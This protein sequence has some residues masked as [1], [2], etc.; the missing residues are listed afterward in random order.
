MPVE[1]EYARSLGLTPEATI[2]RFAERLADYGAD[3]RR[4]AAGSEARVVAEALAANGARRVGIPT[5]L[6]AALRPA[7]RRADRGLGAA[8]ARRRRP[9]GARRGRDHVLARDRGDRNDL[10]HRSRRRRATG[11]DAR[12]RPARVRGA[13]R[14]RRRER[15]GGDRRVGRGRPR[16]PADHVGVRAVRDERHRDEPRRR[17]CTGRGGWWSCSF[18]DLRDATPGSAR[19]SPCSCRRPRLRLL[20]DHELAHPQPPHLELADREPLDAGAA[21]REPSD[22][23]R[24]DRERADRERPPRRPRRSR[25]RRRRSRRPNEHL[26]AWFHSFHELMQCVI[27]PAHGRRFGTAPSWAYD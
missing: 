14:A 7:A 27:D 2:E 24:T 25:R 23:E 9:R 8:D 5:D 18:S 10:P 6:P 19:L 4:C 1:R 15:A 16:R 13:G 21:D 11:V 20:V 17:A 26:V 12:A 22:R 3:V